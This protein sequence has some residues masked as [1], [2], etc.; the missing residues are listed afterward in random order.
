[1]MV[2]AATEVWRPQPAHSNVQALVSSC[3]GFATTA[4]RANKPVGPTR[5]DQIPD[6]RRLVAEALLEF[7]Q[8]A[9]E[10]GAG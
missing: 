7:D 9:R 2:P 3:Q 5:R 1:M 8:G 4:A 10:V 6:A